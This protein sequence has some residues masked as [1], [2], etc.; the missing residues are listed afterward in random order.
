MNQQPC[1]PRIKRILMGFQDSAKRSLNGPPDT[2]TDGCSIDREQSEDTVES[3]VVKPEVPAN[4]TVSSQRSCVS[5]NGTVGSS[6]H[7]ER[8]RPRPAAG[9]KRPVLPAP[10]LMAA[11]RGLETLEL[12]ETQVEGEKISC[13]NVGGE[14]RLCLPQLLSRVLYTVPPLTLQS[15]TDALH[16]YFAECGAAQLE[17]LKQAGVLPNMV[18]RSGLVTLTDAMRICAVLLHDNPPCHAAPSDMTVIPVLHECFGGCRGLFWP[19]EYQSSSSLC[20]ECME[21]HGRLSP[22]QFISH[23]HTNGESHTCHWGFDNKKWR[24][25]LLVSD[26]DL[27]PE[28]QMPLQKLLDKMKLL[29]IGKEDQEILQVVIVNSSSSTVIITINYYYH[30]CHHYHY[31]HVYKDDIQKIG[32]TTVLDRHQLRVRVRV[33]VSLRVRVAVRFGSLSRKY[34][35]GH[36]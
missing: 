35:Y 9:F 17:V 24:S 15:V 22:E 26:E 30:H 1:Y 4:D 10:L 7:Q 32:K 8:S 34:S 31:Y 19:V 16:V 33:R 20:I 12:S 23:S 36:R 2:V 27:S 14:A 6:G 18:A 13:F 25:Y 21:C 28:D 29:F 5:N 3:S 11:D